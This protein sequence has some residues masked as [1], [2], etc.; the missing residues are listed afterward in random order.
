MVSQLTT[1]VCLASLTGP[2]PYHPMAILKAVME[3]RSNT[4]QLV[5]KAL[6]RNAPRLAS[7]QTV[8]LNLDKASLEWLEDEIR[9]G[10]QTLPKVN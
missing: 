4:G 8:N 2:P 1:G 7:Q 6:E 3:N 10:D 5:M 9:I